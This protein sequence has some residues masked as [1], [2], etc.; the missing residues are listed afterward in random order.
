MRTLVQYLVLGVLGMWV[1]VYSQDYSG[2]LSV[3][4]NPAY[5]GDIVSLMLKDGYKFNTYTGTRHKITVAN[6]A[7]EII[8]LSKNLISFRVPYTVMPG[9]LNVKYSLDD[10]ASGTA[11][12]RVL[13]GTP[14]TPLFPNGYDPDPAK[15]YGAPIEAGKNPTGFPRGP[16]VFNP[17]GGHANV[18]YSS[19]T[20]MHIVDGKFSGGIAGNKDEWS[21][22]IPMRGRF[23]NL[24]MDYCAESGTLYVLSDWSFTSKQPNVGT[25]YSYFEIVTGNGSEHWKIKIFNDP[26]RGYVITRNDSVVSGVSGPVIGGAYSYS[27]SPLAP[28]SHT[29]YEFAIK[30]KP[31]EF[32]MPVY[33]NP[34]E[35][36]GPVVMC[37]DARYGLVQDPS[38]FHGTLSST[39]IT[40]RKDERYVPLAGAAG[41][42]TEPMVIAGMLGGNTS[43]FG[44][45]GAVNPVKNCLSKHEIDGKFTRFADSSK[46]WSN[47][48]AASGR[49]SDLYADYCNGTLYILN[50]WVLGSEE[51]DK[52]NCYNLFELTTGN[53]TQHWGIYVY[54][55]L[56]KGIRVFLNGID[57][58][59]D[60]DIVK[61][62]K[63]GMDSSP[64]D[65][66]PHT[67]YEFG[68]KADEGAWKMF[69]CDPGPSS[70]CDNGPGNNARTLQTGSSSGRETGFTGADSKDISKFEISPWGQR[71]VQFPILFENNFNKPEINESVIVLRTLDDASEWGGSKY[72]VTVNFEGGCLVPKAVTLDPALAIAKKISI[73]E[74]LVIGKT[75]TATIDAPNGF[76]NSGELLR[77]ICT[78]DVC[79]NDTTLINGR[80]E[81]KNEKRVM[82]YLPVLEG[83]AVNDRPFAGNTDELKANILSFTSKDGDY[84]KVAFELKQPEN[85]HIRVYDQTGKL[86]RSLPRKFYYAGEYSE[87]LSLNGLQTGSLYVMITTESGKSVTVPFV[88]GY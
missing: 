46:E 16:V 12:L 40:L 43:N 10:G 45:T 55:S 3:Q 57:V 26:K 67:V 49:F 22:I 47:V 30:V 1:S 56:R 83:Y 24:Y 33:S 63:F 82:R 35:S 52:E 87:Q 72:S 66:S 50:D 37:N 74:S 34:V 18:P 27:T 64:R 23:S 28:F 2:S 21:D 14:T 4:P 48:R 31:G 20:P 11:T 78:S 81:I 70:F 15:Q 53:G 51:P 86:L 75:V 5:A 68:I 38:Y 76:S 80:V 13:A 32:V 77:I 42:A 88:I 29:M 9:N 60:P 71:E 44:A 58:S 59:L 69:F 6:Q 41:L 84:L 65:A 61:G 36:T 17:S 62:G 8:S 19:C 85:L 79:I 73:Q 54:H 7:A 25:C 39:G